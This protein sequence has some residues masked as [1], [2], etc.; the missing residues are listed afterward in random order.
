MRI[1][2]CVRALIAVLGLAAV[3]RPVASNEY[4]NDTFY[5]VHRVRRSSRRK[6]IPEEGSAIQNGFMEDQEMDK[7]FHHRNSR[8]S[9]LLDPEDSG[10]RTV[11]CCPTV[12]EMIEP[13]G[14]S[15]QEGLL[16]E[17]YRDENYIQ[18]FYEYSCQ[19]SVVDKPCKFINKKLHAQSRCVQR[20]SFSY[21]L[22]KNTP[23]HRNKNFPTFPA[24]GNGGATY[25]LDYIKV[26]SG[27]SCVVV[28]KNKKRKNTRKQH[29]KT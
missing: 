28:N 21:A 1:A 5:E 17:L 13:L 25:T 10:N 26:R 24:H 7:R 23:S 19:H 2:Y 6:H 27:C 12:L 9:H 14:G 15:N 18:R 20:H 22:V 3:V 11:D 4:F 8:K 16:V 29:A